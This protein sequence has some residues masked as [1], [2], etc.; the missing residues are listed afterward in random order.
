ME[1]EEERVRER[2]R[3]RK[4]ESERRER[5]RERNSEMREKERETETR[6]EIGD[7]ISLSFYRRHLLYDLWMSS[8]SNP[9]IKYLR[10]KYNRT[11]GAI[12]ISDLFMAL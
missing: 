3:K 12:P 10:Q 9:A 4:R 11:K 1:N 7:V 8:G 2:E 6:L 5:D